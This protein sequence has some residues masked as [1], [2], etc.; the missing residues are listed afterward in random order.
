MTKRISNHH[1][2]RRYE[3]TT[4]ERSSPRTQPQR[5]QEMLYLE[6]KI[7]Y[8]RLKEDCEYFISKYTGKAAS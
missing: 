6:E 3:A 2:S 5:R 4:K 1:R 7:Q 8:I